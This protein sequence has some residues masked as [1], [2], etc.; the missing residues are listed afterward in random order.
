MEIPLLASVL[1]GL[2]CA[3]VPLTGAD[4]FRWALGFVEDDLREKLRRLRVNTRP[5]HGWLI[6]W[7]VAVAAVSWLMRDRVGIG[8]TTPCGRDHCALEAA[9]GRKEAGCV[10]QDDLRILTHHHNAAH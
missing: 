5:L 9:L 8:C 7:L 2:S 6:V 1:I 4:L 3:L 10:D